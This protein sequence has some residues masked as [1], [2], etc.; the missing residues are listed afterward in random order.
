MPRLAQLADRGTEL[1]K[2]EVKVTAADGQIPE[3]A[4]EDDVQPRMDR[5]ATRPVEGRPRVLHG[6]ELSSDP[7]LLVGE[8]DVGL[9]SLGSGGLEPLVLPVSQ[10]VASVE[11][12][13]EGLKRQGRADSREIVDLS[14]EDLEL[15][16]VALLQEVVEP[17]DTVAAGRLLARHQGAEE[18]TRRGITQACSDVLLREHL[19][20]FQIP[21]FHV[22]LH[23]VHTI[24]PRRRVARVLGTFR[25]SR[26]AS[27]PG[28]HRPWAA[29]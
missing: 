26:A 4:I 18:A 16:R 6:V 8:L 29:S 2:G 23:R 21:A 12:S 7:S 10:V 27:S 20:L 5:R 15:G 22:C 11:S 3:D 24:P 14:E 13:G 28:R 1:L 25:R 17:V 9:L 19:H